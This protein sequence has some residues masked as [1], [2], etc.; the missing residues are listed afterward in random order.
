MKI[1]TIILISLT[2]LFG[3]QSEINAQKDYSIRIGIGTVAIDH[4][5][6]INFN[7]SIPLIRTLEIQP[8]FSY[9]N[10]FTQ[11]MQLDPLDLVENDFYKDKLSN[12]YQSD[13]NC[14]L[15]IIDLCL[16]F[17]P[18]ELSRSDLQKKHELF[19]GVGYGFKHYIQAFI[20]T[21]KTDSGD[22]ISDYR[23][24]IDKT[25]DSTFLFG[26]NY[27]IKNKISIGT[28]IETQSFDEYLT[29]FTGFS[30]GIIL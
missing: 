25:F 2:I 15:G 12:S 24:N 22:F 18:F 11:D 6:Y 23:F 9:A 14:N 26:Y 17:K 20:T 30:I 4:G 16:V 13:N 3:Y 29:I 1:S 19:I 27:K 28:K 7:S 5:Y 10:T 8:S 21:K